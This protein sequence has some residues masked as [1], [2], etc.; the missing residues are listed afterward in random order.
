MGRIADALRANLRELAQS[1]ARSLRA[2][3]AELRAA[4][5]GAPKEPLEDLPDD[6]DKHTVRELKARCRGAG[7]HGYS[8]L[9]K[10][11]LINLLRHGASGAVAAKA[12]RSATISVEARLQRIESLL[13]VVAEQVG[14]AKDQITDLIGTD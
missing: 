7:L 4:S 8:G 13:C 1:D 14:V 12:P 2:I 3:D 5:S 9:N 10:A 6:L 11:D